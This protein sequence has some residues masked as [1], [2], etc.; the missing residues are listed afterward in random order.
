MPLV[1]LSVNTLSLPYVYHYYLKAPTLHHG[2]GTAQDHCDW[3]KEIQTSQ[4]IFSHSRMITRAA[5]PLSPMHTWAGDRSQL[6]ETKKIKC[7]IERN[8]ANS[9]IYHSSLTLFFLHAWCVIIEGNLMLTHSMYELYKVKTYQCYVHSV[10]FACC[11][12]FAFSQMLC[13][14]SPGKFPHRVHRHAGQVN[15]QFKK[16]SALSKY[17][18]V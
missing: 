7:Q 18:H 1:T 6:D 12:S 5:R 3:F 11:D 14:F 16:K 9:K 13:G 17:K 2:L 10:V 15:W 8:P 4:S